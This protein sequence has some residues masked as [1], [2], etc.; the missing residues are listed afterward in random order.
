MNRFVHICQSIDFETAEIVTVADGFVQDIA[1]HR[2]Y[3]TPYWN[4]DNPL[5][6]RDAFIKKKIVW[7][8]CGGFVL[9]YFQIKIN[10]C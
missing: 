7:S 1:Y 2:H 9:S 3:W 10:L 8:F 6:L 4:K 5:T